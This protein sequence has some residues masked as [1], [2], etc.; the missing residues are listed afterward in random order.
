MIKVNLLKDH[1]APV[2]EKQSIITTPQISGIG[3]VYI[4]AIIVAAAVLGYWWIASGNAIKEARVE[5]QSLEID[6]KEMETLRRQFVELERKKQEIQGRINI[7]EKLLESQKG[8]VKLMNAVI[9]AVPQNRDIWL[10]SLEQTNSDVKV[11]GETR[12]PESLPDFMDALAK[13]G[14]F[15]SIDIEQI[16]RRDEISNFSILCASK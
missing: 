3:Y 16:E 7:I 9:Q 11:K 14:V 15:A 8:P 6:L 2:E 1:S 13:S 4:A 10:T 5:N 12:N